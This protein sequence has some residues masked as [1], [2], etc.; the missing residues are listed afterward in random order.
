MSILATFG[1]FCSREAQQ[2]R[3]HRWRLGRQWRWLCHVQYLAVVRVNETESQLL[4]NSNFGT[5][6]LV[7]L[8]GFSPLFF[9]ITHQFDHISY[10][11]SDKGRSQKIGKE[12]NPSVFHFCPHRTLPHLPALQT[13][14]AGFRT[15]VHMAVLLSSF[16]RCV[17]LSKVLH[18][19]RSTVART[20]STRS[21][22]SMQSFL[23]TSFVITV[24]G[25]HFV[26]LQHDR[27]NKCMASLSGPCGRHVPNI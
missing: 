9:L 8:C 14:I 27:G 7:L 4:W 11:I 17:S 1:V 13:S 5:V 6:V 12:L 16:P 18:L 26:C 23:M 22:F 15:E 10:H 20:A 2:V 21:K 19:S 25:L 3:R 24:G